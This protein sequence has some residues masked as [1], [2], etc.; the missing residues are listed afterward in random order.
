MRRIL[1][2]LYIGFAWLMVIW[3]LATI[4][5]A[6]MSLFVRNSLWQTHT[7]F[8]WSSELPGLVL[9]VLGL[10]RWIPRRLVGWLV[11]VLVLH[12]VQTVLPGLRDELPYLAALHPLNASIL[13]YVSYL[14]AKRARELLLEQPQ[15]ST[16]AAG[17]TGQAEA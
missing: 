6:G 16:Q 2:Y 4:V 13:T 10:L 9:I 8:G 11:A 1:S 14:H 17:L 3:L 7:E 12:I 15:E 5:M